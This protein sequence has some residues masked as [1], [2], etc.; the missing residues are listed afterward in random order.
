MLIQHFLAKQLKMV[1]VCNFSLFKDQR[2]LSPRTGEPLAIAVSDELL[3]IAEEGCV[4]EIYPLTA[5]APLA[6]IRTV[7]PVVECVFNARG[8]AIVTLERKNESSRMFARV[9]FK[10]RESSIDRPVRVSLI[11]TLTQS[12]LSGSS[13]TVSAEIV[14]LPADECF[15][16]SC[17]AVCKETGRIAVGMDSR[18]RLFSLSPEYK[19]TSIVSHR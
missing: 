7:A 3:F 15:S 6:Q 17:V 19:G 2:I 4:L 14:E 13:Q 10:W 18:I 5:E 12:L 11:G 9:Y 1:K 16:V 8:D